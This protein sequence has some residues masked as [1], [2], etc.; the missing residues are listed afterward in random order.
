L[1]QYPRSETKEYVRLPKQSL[2]PDVW[3]ATYLNVFENVVTKGN[4]VLKHLGFGYPRLAEVDRAYIDALP[5]ADGTTVA[6]DYVFEKALENVRASWLELSTALDAG[7]KELFT[8]KNASLD[9]GLADL[10]GQPIFVV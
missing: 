6:Y 3:Y 9:T 4:G 1:E 8:L 10:G 2:S 5:I 7:N